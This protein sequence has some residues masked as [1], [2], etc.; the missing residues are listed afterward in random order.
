MISQLT[1]LTSRN[2][3]LYLRDKGAVFFSL[4]S[5]LIVIALMVFFL[6]NINIESITH[7]L[8]EF[9]GR[10]VAK[11]S[12]NAKLLVLA[13]TCAGIL[14]INAV[15]VTLS[16]YSKNLITDRTS[17]ILHSIYT[18]PISRTLIAASYI[19][20]SW[21]ASL[22]ICLG[23]LFITEVYSISQGLAP[24]SFFTHIR[25]LGMIMINSFTYAALMY[26]A[27]YLIKSEGAWSGMGTVVGTLVG[28][29]GGIYLPIGSLSEQIGKLMKCTP[30][31]Y[32]TS[33]FRKVMVDDILLK[34]FEGIPTEVI[35]SYKEVMGIDLFVGGKNVDMNLE[36]LLLF[37]AGLL[38]LVMGILLLVK[39]SKADR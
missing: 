12:E 30:I 11:D 28:F 1:A 29:L 37:L 17:Q 38:F 8:E 35:D 21:I 15:T 39:R 34:T 3:K 24:F 23:T 36:L 26:A 10:D 7:I 27:A 22:I 16:V 20:S 19:L 32:G 4:L 18:A 31:I 33:M 5:M 14:S 25:L 2:L 13:W 9:P 6:G